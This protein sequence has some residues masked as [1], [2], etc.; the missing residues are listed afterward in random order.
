MKL[1]FQSRILLELPLYHKVYENHLEQT[2]VVILKFEWVNPVGIWGQNDVTS[3]QRRCD[4]ITSHRLDHVAS[5]LIGR[6]FWPG[7]GLP[8]QRPMLSYQKINPCQNVYGKKRV[9]V[10]STIATTLQKRPVKITMYLGLNIITKLKFTTIYDRCAILNVL[11]YLT[12]N[13]ESW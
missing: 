11:N 10:R 8:S 12:K 13:F 1:Y 6:H 2:A 7:L 3:Y 9:K 5:T 4:V